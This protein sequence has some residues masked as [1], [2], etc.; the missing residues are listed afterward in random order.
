MELTLSY[1]LSK[2]RTDIPGVPRWWH[3]QS[4]HSKPSEVIPFIEQ[5]LLHVTDVRD[6]LSLLTLVAFGTCELRTYLGAIPLSES[7]HRS[8][9][10]YILC[11]LEWHLGLEWNLGLIFGGFQLPAIRWTIT[12]SG[13]CGICLHMTF[14]VKVEASRE[15]Q[16]WD[17]LECTKHC[18]NCFHAAS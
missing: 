11:L 17:L 16:H 18:M 3:C 7:G 10:F 12:P 4:S 8:G 15:T 13:Y 9:K 2:K 1:Y 6:S 14:H 5:R